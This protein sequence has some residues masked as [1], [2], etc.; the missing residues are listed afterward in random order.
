MLATII[1]NINQTKKTELLT[2]KYLNETFGINK[3]ISKEICK[4]LFG[5][6]IMCL[7]VYPKTESQINVLTSLFKEMNIDFEYRSS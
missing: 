1:N 2:V 4:K 5:L 7:S 6:N 3:E